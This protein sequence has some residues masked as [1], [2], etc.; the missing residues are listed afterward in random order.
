MVNRILAQH[1]RRSAAWNA[2]RQGRIA[3]LARIEA[4]SEDDYCAYEQCGKLLPE[5][6]ANN[7]DAWS[8]KGYCD[9]A[10]AGFDLIARAKWTDDEVH[11]SQRKNMMAAFGNLARFARK[12][13]GLERDLVLAQI[14][15]ELPNAKS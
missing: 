13:S 10:C 11:A 8:F 2:Y 1:D 4:H 14:T 5:P 3:D 6:N 15:G 7:Q 9:V 12:Q